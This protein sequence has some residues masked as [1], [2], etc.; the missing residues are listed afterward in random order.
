MRNY[1]VRCKGFVKTNETRVYIKDYYDTYQ[2]EYISIY[3]RGY[4]CRKCG[5]IHSV[6]NKECG[7]I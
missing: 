3:A 7:S 2:K 6:A 4:I 5:Q 1:C